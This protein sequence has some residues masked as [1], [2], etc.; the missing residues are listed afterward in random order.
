MDSYFRG[1]G[2]G[3]SV[4]RVQASAFDVGSDVTM[5]RYSFLHIQLVFSHLFDHESILIS[6]IIKSIRI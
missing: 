2:V 1:I 3:V 6:L 5:L 4:V